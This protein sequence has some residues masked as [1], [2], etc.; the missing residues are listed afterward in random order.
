MDKNKA[1][2]ALGR[3][4]EPD[5]GQ[6]VVSLGLVGALQVSGPEVQV[7]LKLLNPSQERRREIEGEVRRVLLEAGAGAVKVDLSFAIPSTRPPMAGNLLAGVQNVVAV[8]SGKGG[9]GKSTVAVNLALA[10]HAEGARVGLLDADVYGPSIPA[11]MGLKREELETDGR[12]I[13]PA[14]SFGLKVMSMGLVMEEGEAV[15]W[16][17]PML[18]GVVRQFLEEVAWG[19]LDYLLIDLP[20]GT[21]D[22]QLSLC[23]TV[24]LGGAVVVST[25]Q[26]VALGVAVKAINM[27]E[28]LNTP[29]LGILENMS[30]YVCPHCGE[31]DDV[32]GHGG[33]AQASARLGIPFLGGVPLESRVRCSGD[34]GKPVVVANPESP[35]AQAL[36]RAARLLAG[37]LVVA[38]C[39]GYDD[40]LATMPQL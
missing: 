24:P 12:Q 37:R 21:G 20:P 38:A 3:V 27:F 34:Q 8:A 5:L 35:A 32:F 40:L 16:R 11:L 15:I 22:V 14:E 9:V 10:L 28:K 36:L 4:L 7:G 17:G 29:V 33:A 6:D 30:T 26:D 18:H 19:D 31:R 13:Q 1:M 39:Q 2:E 23:Q 25:P